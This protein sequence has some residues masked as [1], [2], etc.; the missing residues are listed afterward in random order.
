[1]KENTHLKKYLISN[2]C[3]TTTKDRTY[4]R[5]R[6]GRRRRK[7][8]ET[9]VP[10]V[11]MTELSPNSCQTPDPGSPGSPGRKDAGKL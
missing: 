11:T 4:T 10:N 9:E 6:N 2:D 8:K 5:D 3:K 7:K 1:M